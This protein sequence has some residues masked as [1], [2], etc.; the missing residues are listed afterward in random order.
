VV[1][2]NVMTAVSIAG[3]TAKITG[4]T[5]LDGVGNY[6]YVVTAVDNRTATDPNPVSNPDRFG[7]QLKDSSGA[8]VSSL[9]FAPIPV[10]DGNVFVGR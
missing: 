10:A 7:L 5:T 6:R 8:L 4:K 3:T 1:K 9:T 2:G